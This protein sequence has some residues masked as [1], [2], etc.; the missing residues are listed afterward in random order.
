MSL[1]LLIQTYFQGVAEYPA[2]GALVDNQVVLMNWLGVIATVLKSHTTKL[3]AVAASGEDSD[4]KWRVHRRKWIRQCRTAAQEDLLGYGF[5]TLV[6]PK[7]KP[8]LTGMWNAKRIAPANGNKHTT[9]T[10]IH[11]LGSAGCGQLIHR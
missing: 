7:P 1:R 11:L 8:W 4:E 6:E 3:D 5:A 9:L 10:Y 2:F